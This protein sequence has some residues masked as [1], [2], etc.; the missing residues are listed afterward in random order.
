MPRATIRRRTRQT[1][2]NSA[3]SDWV[4]R[5]LWRNETALRFNGPHA[6]HGRRDF[7]SELHW[8]ICP[9]LLLTGEEDPTTPPVF[10]EA[11]AAGLAESRL[12]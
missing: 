4:S 9:F 5:I 10:S 8:I 11:I 1:Y 7:R 3:S 2:S 12:T 6:E